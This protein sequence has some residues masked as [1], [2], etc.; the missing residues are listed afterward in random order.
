MAQVYSR[1]WVWFRQ[2]R[3]N[4]ENMEYFQISSGTKSCHRHTVKGASCPI[5]IAVELL[6][7]KKGNM[8]NN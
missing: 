1:N 2:R 6:K 8:I 3:S 5:G 7:Q 4:V